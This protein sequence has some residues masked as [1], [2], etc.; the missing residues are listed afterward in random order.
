MPYDMHKETSQKEML[1]FLFL[2]LSI[3]SAFTS[4]FL[5]LLQNPKTSSDAKKQFQNAM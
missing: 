2:C 5:A 4:F 3:S 1:L